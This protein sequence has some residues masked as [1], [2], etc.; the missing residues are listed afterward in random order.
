MRP[1]PARRSCGVRSDRVTNRFPRP[2]VWRSGHLSLCGVFPSGSIILPRPSRPTSQKLGRCW[3]RRAGPPANRSSS[4]NMAET[5]RMANGAI[6]NTISRDVR[7]AEV[8]IP[9]L[10]RGVRHERFLMPPTQS[11]ADYWEILRI[12]S[13]DRSARYGTLWLSVISAFAVSA[14][15]RGGRRDRCPSLRRPGPLQGSAREEGLERVSAA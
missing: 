7:L 1:K 8:C 12:G 15:P 4:P 13:N 6:S 9:M 11:S 5:S 14:F 10:R 2:P 3:R